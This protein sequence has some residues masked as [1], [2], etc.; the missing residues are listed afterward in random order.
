MPLTYTKGF[1][2]H[3]KISYSDAMK[4][5]VASSGFYALI[6][7][8]KELTDINER[9][10]NDLSG[11]K[12]LK[13]WALHE[14]KKID[15]FIQGYIFKLFLNYDNFDY[16]NF[17][18]KKVILK[19]TKRI[20]TEIVIEEAFKNVFIKKFNK[21][22]MVEYHMLRSNMVS[23][24]SMIEVLSKKTDTDLKDIFIYVEDA[25]INNERT[26]N[27]LND[28]LGGSVNVRS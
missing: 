26:S 24:E 20:T 11:L 22:F 1:N 3:P 2:P 21:Y 15:D 8:E 27:I 18:P 7:M 5:G 10:K 16:K 23:Y 12:V 17:D 9:F 6:N 4:T 13:F 19:K 25:L 28:K 14:N